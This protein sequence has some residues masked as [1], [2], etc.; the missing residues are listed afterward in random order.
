MLDFN[1]D[2]Q[3]KQ[4]LILCDLMF[5]GW[6]CGWTATD[7]QIQNTMSRFQIFQ[8]GGANLLFGR[9][10]LDNCMKMKEMGLPGEEGERV[11]LAALLDPSMVFSSFI[12]FNF[13]L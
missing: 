10:F 6:R 2:V 3:S 9:I 8:K 1:S 12:H 13:Y 4:S 5:F 11:S 7:Q